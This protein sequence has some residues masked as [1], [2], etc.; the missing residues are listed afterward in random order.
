MDKYYSVLGVSPSATFE[1][2]TKAYKKRLKIVH[3]DR[4]DV[5]TQPDEWSQ[6]NKMLQELNEAYD[7]IKKNHSD[8]NSTSDKEK[9]AYKETRNESTSNKSTDHKESEGYKRSEPHRKGITRTSVLNLTN[10]HI[11]FINSLFKDRNNL[12]ILT[13]NIYVK[14]SILIVS[15]GIICLM[16]SI[17]IGSNTLAKDDFTF[18]VI[19]TLI[20]TFFATK[21]GIFTYKYLRSRVKPCVLFTPMYFIHIDF[22]EIVFGYEWEID[23]IKLHR[24]QG[25]FPY[26][27]LRLGDYFTSFSAPLLGHRYFRKK[28]ERIDD[29]RSNI[30]DRAQWF[31]Q[32]D[33]LRD[34]KSSPKIEVKN[35]I[36]NFYPYAVSISITLVASIIFINTITLT[37]YSA[38]A[39][40]RIENYASRE[41]QH[42]GEQNPPPVTLQ[43][44]IPEFNHPSQPLPPSGREYNYS[45]RKGVAPLQIVVPNAGDN[46]Y[47]KVVTFENKPV[48]AVFIRSGDTVK[49][50][51]PLG[52]YK[53]KYATGETWYGQ[54][55]LFGPGTSA[56]I[57][58]SDFDFRVEDNRYSGYTIE[59][60][61]QANGNLHSRNISIDEF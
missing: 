5:R 59:L 7:W 25:K 18:Y 45:S 23:L 4:F 46:Y 52:T 24:E 43:P 55:Y 40:A 21:Y 2:I 11:H 13:P 27:N 28:F 37:K 33:I 47:V 6:A 31:I 58:E 50:R 12:K 42:I 34:I 57:A 56:T 16:F 49:I 26:V 53:I 44:A 1:E 29:I 17:F 39:K 30:S 48:K 14:S 32:N 54:K 10:T 15:S 3:P 36:K 51:V 61:K 35:S 8:D 41:A 9:T 38:P 19:L 60:I 20:A 22:N